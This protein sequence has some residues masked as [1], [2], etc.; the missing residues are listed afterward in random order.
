MAQTGEFWATTST[1]AFNG[2]GSIIEINDDGTGFNIM[3]SLDDSTGSYPQG[4][5]IKA[6]NKSLY[7]MALNG[8][9]NGDG[10]IFSFTPSDNTYTDVYDFNDSTG[11]NPYGNLLLASDGNFYGMTH[12]GGAKGFG[13]I[14][15]FNPD[16][17]SY[18]DIHDFNDTLGG[19]PYGSLIQA[20]DSE[21]YGMT[22]LGGD[23]ALNSGLGC[24]VI[25]SFNFYDSVYNALYYFNFNNGAFPRG[26]LIKATNG[27]FYG[28]TAQ[29]GV[30]SE[31]VIFS[32]DVTNDFVKILHNF[33]TATGAVPFGSLLQAGNAM[34]YGM[35]YSGGANNDGVIFG[36]D[37]FGNSYNDLHDFDSINGE[38]PYGSLIQT[39]TS[40]LCGTTYYGGANDAGTIF[41]FDAVNIIFN[42]LFDFNDTTGSNPYADLLQL[43]ANTGIKQLSASNYQLAIYPNP[44]NGKVTIVSETP[45]DEI[46]VTNLLGQVVL[47]SSQPANKENDQQIDLS[48]LPSGLYFVTVTSQN[49]TTTRKIVVNK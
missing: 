9:A 40:K 39:S 29:G 36:I 33:N 10:V 45:I 48:N 13:V 37:T 38:N 19:L 22:F 27:K 16:S 15:R 43:P 30:D 35:T 3:Y 31:G 21:L 41:S 18:S 6:A 25:F 42:K 7:G 26:N 49:E 20:G 2:S 17:N 46:R 34:L 32:I 12:F 8:G 23:T 1:G 24:G 4:N 47:Y 11:S 44:T 14:F 28:M 5:L